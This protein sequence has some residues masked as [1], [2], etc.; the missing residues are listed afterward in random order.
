MAV[1]GSVAPSGSCANAAGWEGFGA[2]TRITV[3]DDAGTVISTGAVTNDPPAWVNDHCRFRIVVSDLPDAVSYLFEI[4]HRPGP[5]VMRY[6][7]EAAG[8]KAD[9]ILSEQ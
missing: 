3:H 5:R 1:P 7:L 9:L 8:W 4:G 2:G 6:V